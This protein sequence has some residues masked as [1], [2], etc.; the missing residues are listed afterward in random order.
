MDPDKVDMVINWKIPMNCDL[1]HGFIGS[2]GYLADNI[3][4]IRIPMSTL[5]ALTEDTILF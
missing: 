2:V 3:S 4:N 5:S 1:L